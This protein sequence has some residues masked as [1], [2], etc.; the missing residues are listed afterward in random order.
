MEKK[1]FLKK[2]FP[3]MDIHKPAPQ[4]GGFSRRVLGIIKFILGLC[5]LPFV[6]SLSLVFIKELNLI[7]P[8]LQVYFWSGIISFL[9]LYLFIWEPTLIYD[10]GQKLVEIIFQFFHPLLKFAPYLLPV[11]TLVLFIIY[12]LA[13]VIFKPAEIINYFVFLLGFSISLHLVFSAKS[14]R[15]KQGDFLKA[16]YIFGFSFVY[17]VNLT[18]LSLGLS[19][20]FSDFSFIDFSRGSFDIAKDIFYAV[21]KQF[22]FKVG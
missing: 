11:Y 9:A 5:L 3:K 16:N 18:L 13:A 2:E 17:L 8:K 21:F 22:F 10:K 7:D 20:I 19:F 14:I 4:I 12:A 15:A 6:Y 1:E